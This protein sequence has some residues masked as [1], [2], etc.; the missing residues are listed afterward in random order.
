LAQ[1]RAQHGPWPRQCL[2][3]VLDGRAQ[4]MASTQDVSELLKATAIGHAA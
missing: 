1:D 4:L 2:G 3:G